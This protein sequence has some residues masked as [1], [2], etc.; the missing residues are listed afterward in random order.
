MRSV[1]L[2]GSALSQNDSNIIGRTTDLK[3]FVPDWI[4]GQ[5]ASHRANERTNQWTQ[6]GNTILYC[7]LCASVRS[8]SC[9][10]LSRVGDECDLNGCRLLC[11]GK[12]RALS[13]PN[14]IR[15]KCVA[16]LGVLNSSRPQI[17]S[18]VIRG[19]FGCF[20]YFVCLSKYRVTTNING[21]LWIYHNEQW[22]LVVY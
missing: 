21:N 22:Y 17:V 20:I 15:S 8:L 6:T 11:P 16:L 18:F 3:T 10:K 19:T 4:P 5:S 14:I 13:G 9:A 7:R 1:A 12:L 2:Q